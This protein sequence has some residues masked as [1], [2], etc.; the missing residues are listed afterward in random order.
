MSRYKFDL[1]HLDE[2]LIEFRETLNKAID[3]LSKNSN[4]PSMIFK[5]EDSYDAFMFLGK[6]IHNFDVDFGFFSS[7]NIGSF[8]SSLN[9]YIYEKRAEI[10]FDLANELILLGKVKKRVEKAK[11]KYAKNEKLVNSLGNSFFLSMV[12]LRNSYEIY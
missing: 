8:L 10:K 5:E 9:F 3:H 2:N 12:L 4:E 11:R 7:K 6:A 1:G